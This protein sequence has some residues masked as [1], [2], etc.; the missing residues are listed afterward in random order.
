MNIDA[1]RAFLSVAE[2]TSFSTAAEQLHLS[3]PA[4]SKRIKQLEDELGQRL[5][6][7]LA[8]RVHLTEAGRALLPGARAILLEVEESRRRL[9]QLTDRV[10]GRLSI[11]SSH[12]IG[13]HRLPALL[14][15]FIRTF[16]E[17]DLDLQFLDSETGCRLVEKG[18]LELAVVTLPIKT[19]DALLSTPVWDDPL[20]IMVAADHPL[21]ACPVADCATLADHP[22]ILP[23]A[24]TYTRALIDRAMKPHHLSPMIRLETNYLETIRSMVSI[25]MGWSTL[26]L[27]MLDARLRV[28]DVPEM[29][30]KRQLGFIR[31][32]GR[33]LSNAARAL[34]RSALTENE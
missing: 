3:Q 32:Q 34:I 24:G 16:P 8:R 4:V 31:H 19:P 11:G 20:M 22:A 17:V 5:F 7:R 10:T 25:G 21:T 15:R 27:T 1:L 13:L 9:S 18:D 6:N 12:H 33:T 23:A 14:R 28:I 30:M 29:K 2:H 26:P